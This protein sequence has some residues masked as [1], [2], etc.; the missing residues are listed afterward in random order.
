[1]NTEFNSVEVTPNIMYELGSIKAQLIAINEKLDKKEE[2][3]DEEIKGLQSRVSKLEHQRAGLIG[4]AAGIGVILNT[5]IIKMVPWQS[6][7]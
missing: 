4:L 3:Q 7:F 1:M 5:A 2:A 6:L